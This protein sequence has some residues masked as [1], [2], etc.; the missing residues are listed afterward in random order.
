MHVDTKSGSCTAQPAQAWLNVSRGG[1]WSQ[2]RTEDT[3]ALLRGVLESFQK[4]GARGFA[5][6]M[7]LA[8]QYHDEHAVGPMSFTVPGLSGRVHVW[9]GEGGDGGQAE[10]DVGLAVP[11][12]AAPSAGPLITWTDIQAGTVLRQAEEGLMGSPSVAALVTAAAVLA[13]WGQ[14]EPPGQQGWTVDMKGSSRHI[15]WHAHG[16]ICTPTEAEE[17]QQP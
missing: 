17:E 10:V 11:P 1:R 12:D 2:C 8:S 9:G 15:H 3:A 4:K 14:A 7:S 5:D 16:L 6:L 13:L